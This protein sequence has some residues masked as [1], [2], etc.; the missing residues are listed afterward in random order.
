[1]LGLVTALCQEQTMGAGYLC[2][3]R[4][5]PPQQMGH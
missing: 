2:P 3:S 5:E 4:T 1:M